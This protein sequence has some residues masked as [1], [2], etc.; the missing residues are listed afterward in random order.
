MSES[1][2]EQR[3]QPTPRVRPGAQPRATGARPTPR[4]RVAGSRRDR[5]EYDRPSSGDLPA[6]ALP[7]AADAAPVDGRGPG[8]A[9]VRGARRPSAL[10]LVLSL[11]CLLAAAGGGLLLWQRLHPAYVDSSVFAAARSSVQALYAYDYRDSKGSV[12]GKLDV[13]TGDLREQYEKDLAQGGIIDTY[14]Q[15]S[16]TTSYEV[17]DVGLQQINDA[18]DTATLVVFGQYVVKSVNSGN[19]PAPQGS[20]CQ[21]T[22]DGGQS[23]TQT[24]RVRVVKADGDWKISELTLL[25]TS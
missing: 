5:D 19:Q 24:V 1:T 10:V 12:Q 2:S 25:T 15:V 18:Q 13:L 16:A 22:P 6:A 3:P 11:V 17:L 9:V 23:C 21:V 14:E 20:E 4:P 8:T 7:R